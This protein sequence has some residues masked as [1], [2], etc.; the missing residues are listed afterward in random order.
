MDE[1]K[2]FS[3]RESGDNKK[4]KI[5]DDGYGLTF[6]TMRNGFQWDRTDV[7]DELLA[8]MREA[9]NDYF[10]IIDGEGN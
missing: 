2:L 1:K 5:E 7:D 4:V 3:I 6:F 8:M 9:I 10:N